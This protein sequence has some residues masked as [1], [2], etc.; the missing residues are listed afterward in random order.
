MTQQEFASRLGVHPVAL[1]RLL[2]G[3]AGKESIAL[4]IDA[5]L[6]SNE[7]PHDMD[8]TSEQEKEE[9]QNAG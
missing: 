5:F 7:F 8:F 9:R 1:N 2:R 4:K 3:H 6:D